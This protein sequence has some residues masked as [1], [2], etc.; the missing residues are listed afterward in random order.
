MRGEEGGRGRLLAKLL[1]ATSASPLDGGESCPEGPGDVPGGVGELQRR[2]G[3]RREEGGE[4]GGV[5]GETGRRKC[6]WLA[7]RGSNRLQ[8]I[9]VCRTGDR[10]AVGGR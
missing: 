8:R 5:Q 2:K 7:Q 3:E 9:L 4:K 1:S 10:H 6:R